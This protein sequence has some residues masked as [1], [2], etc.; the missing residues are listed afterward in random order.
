MRPEDLNHLRGIA[1][2][3][4][5]KIPAGVAVAFTDASVKGAVVRCA[6]VLVFPNGVVSEHVFDPGLD[7]PDANAAEIA[8]IR[9]ALDL[10]AE[11]VVT[12]SL[13]AIRILQNPVVVFVPGDAGILHHQ[14]AHDLSVLARRQ[15][16]E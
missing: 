5:T 1:A 9:F 7:D 3:N 12:D 6:V 2:V 8:A 10:G 4:L 11:Y 13:A 16:K 14:R 15:A